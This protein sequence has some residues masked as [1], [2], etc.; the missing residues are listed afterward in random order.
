MAKLANIILPENTVLDPYVQPLVDKL[1]LDRPNWT[2]TVK[3]KQMIHRYSFGNSVVGGRT[4]TNEDKYLRSVEV[5]EGN[6][7]LGNIGVDYHYSHKVDQRY[8]FYVESWR[9]GAQQRRKTN[10]TSIKMDVIA[11][12]T[13]RLLK[14]MAV[15]EI[16]LKS[17]EGINNGWWQ[18]IQG[19]IRDLTGMR[20]VKSAVDLQL[21]AFCVANNREV[22]MTKF[23]NLIASLRAPEFE[24]VIGKY[25]MAEHMQSLAD[26]K[27]LTDVCIHEGNYVTAAAHD[28]EI[29]A[30]LIVMQFEDM[31]LEWQNRIAVLMLVQDGELI[32]DV[33]YR[34]NDSTFR[35]V[36]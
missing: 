28:Q 9:I 31:P 26:T 30:E 18:V 19:C 22:D 27:K 32:R 4:L 13:K 15:A 8:K 11:R 21:Y 24:D 12:D 20:R 1:A 34:H 6:E 36:T 10:K 5:Y 7:L 16:M 2:F 33:G 35:I 17:R 29:D 3:T 23:T 25:E 14:P